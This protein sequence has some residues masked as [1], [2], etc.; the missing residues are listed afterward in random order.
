MVQCFFGADGRT[1]TDMVSRSILSAV[2]LPISPHQHDLKF[3][4]LLYLN[5]NFFTCL[6]FFDIFLNYFYFL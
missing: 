3:K 2:R 6:Y 4:R 1:R 5:T